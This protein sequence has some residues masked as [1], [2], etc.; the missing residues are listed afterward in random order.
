MSTRRPSTSP[1]TPPPVIDAKF[2]T[3]SGL[4]PRSAAPATTAVASGCSLCASTA[5][6]AVSSS[7][8]EMEVAGNDMRQ[9]R[10]AFCQR[11]GLIHDHRL[12]LFHPLHRRSLFN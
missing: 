12:H 3:L 7:S 1:L 5:T 6:A 8:S 4:M 10:F 9:A 2:A 11:A